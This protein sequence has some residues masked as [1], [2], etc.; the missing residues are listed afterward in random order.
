MHEIGLRSFAFTFRC[1]MICPLLHLGQANSGRI[2]DI[3]LWCYQE[4]QGGP[5]RPRTVA[6]P[7]AAWASANEYSI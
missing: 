3:A 5:S 6:A 2:D 1:S 4:I 7:A